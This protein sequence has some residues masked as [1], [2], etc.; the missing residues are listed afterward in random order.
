MTDSTW[1][2]TVSGLSCCQ[3]NVCLLPVLSLDRLGVVTSFGML[4]L[5]TP[6]TVLRPHPFSAVSMAYFFL[7][8]RG[9]WR[10]NTP[11]QPLSA[12]V[13]IHP[14]PFGCNSILAIR[15][16]LRGIHDICAVG[17]ECP[18]CRDS[19]KEAALGHRLRSLECSVWQSGHLLEILGARREST[20]RIWFCWHLK[21]VQSC[22]VVCRCGSIL[23]VNSSTYSILSLCTTLLR[24]TRLAPGSYR[25]RLLLLSSSSTHRLR[26]RARGLR[27]DNAGSNQ[28]SRRD[29]GLPQ[30]LSEVLAMGRRVGTLGSFDA[31]RRDLDPRWSTT[32]NYYWLRSPQRAA[33]WEPR[34]WRSVWGR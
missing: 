33:N 4:P 27:A 30:R 5:K 10:C 34:Q 32:S 11:A 7:R 9:S 26:L 12:L 2:S 29:H 13:L 31:T 23:S 6:K 22:A 16:L 15:S 24:Q 8:C 1:V 21:G 3:F 18:C 14:R 17:K 19:P 28:Q 20:E 25:C